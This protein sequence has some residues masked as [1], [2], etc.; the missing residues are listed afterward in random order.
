MTTAER[1]LINY[2]A[3]MT[4]MRQ[5]LRDQLDRLRKE[6]PPPEE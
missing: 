3:L 4:E 1:A 5:R 2:A 6:R